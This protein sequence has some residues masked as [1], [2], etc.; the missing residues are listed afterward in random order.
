[1]WF[2]SLAFGLISIQSEKQLSPSIQSIIDRTFFE[3]SAAVSEAFYFY[4]SKFFYPINLY[5]I[6]PK[7]PILGHSLWIRYGASILFL[8]LLLLLLKITFFSRRPYDKLT[9]F[10]L[11][12][13]GIVAG[14]I[15]G[16]FP[17]S[18]M[19]ITHVADR[20]N[21][22]PLPFLILFI[23]L[24]F[25]WIINL[26]HKPRIKFFYL[27]GG[28][29]CI[30]LCVLTFQQSMTWTNSIRLWLHCL[31]FNVLEPSCFYNLG[32]AYYDKGNFEEAKK[33][34]DESLKI[35][36]EFPLPLYAFADLALKQKDLTGAKIYFQ[37][38]SN[39]P[40]TETENYLS[41]KIYSIYMLGMISEKL[42]EN[43]EAIRYYQDVLREYSENKKKNLIHKSTL[44]NLGRLLCKQGRYEEAQLYL[45][46]LKK[47]NFRLGEIDITLGYSFSNS[48][49]KKAEAYFLKALDYFNNHSG[50][51]VVY[52]N[53]YIL[54]QNTKQYAKALSILEQFI[55]THSQDISW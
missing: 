10:C 14:P 16:W 22:H 31:R 7:N 2:L 24:V 30:F 50:Q 3:K 17:T 49:P 44:F 25:Y 21:Y 32:Q 6:Y 41:L 28:I 34:F 4:I 42:E 8:L 23:A 27:T 51:Q 20:Y 53:L 26:I 40:K 13:F 45:L 12:N 29:L 35:N 36:P 5:S 39:S 54:Y 47:E 11:W 9:L 52:W 18:Y 48:D 33:A 46:E 43:P 38:I 55:L 1:L 15:L 37:K 19:K